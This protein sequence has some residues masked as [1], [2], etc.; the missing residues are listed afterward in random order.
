MLNK[1]FQVFLREQVFASL[2]Y[3]SI[4]KLTHKISTRLMV[5][6]L[7]PL[8]LNH[9]RVKAKKTPNRQSTRDWNFTIGSTNRESAK[10]LA[11]ESSKKPKILLP[12]QNNSTES[13][14]TV[15]KIESEASSWQKFKVGVVNL[16]SKFKP[17]S[18]RLVK[19]ENTLSGF[20]SEICRYYRSK[21]NQRTKLAR[22]AEI[23]NNVMIMKYDQSKL[24]PFTKNQISADAL[25]QDEF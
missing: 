7:I 14:G 21:T 12:N 16:N 17:T 10:N 3:S 13:P 15:S 23:K 25:Q 11:I 19:R 5:E 20:S 6:M 8:R 1:S 2:S 9:P 24:Q 4:S 18:P 22:K